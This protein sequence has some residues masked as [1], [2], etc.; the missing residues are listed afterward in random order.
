MAMTIIDRCE[1]WAACYRIR[2]RWSQ[3][4]SFEG[5][6]RSEQREH[7]E[8]GSAP[9]TSRPMLDVVDAQEV[10]SAWQAIP[11]GFHQFLLGAHYVR[12][13]SP[14]KGVREAREFAG[15]KHARVQVTDMEYGAN[16]A[17]AHALLTEQLSLPAV[18]R[19]TRLVERVRIALNLEV[20]L[21]R[22]NIA[23]DPCVTA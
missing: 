13:W 8:Y 10:N 2:M 23:A 19:R 9:P 3:A 17:M 12:R 21:A 16:L 6:Y 4:T 14:E 18:F 15:H 1:N 20:W 5:N 11:D 7:W 22:D